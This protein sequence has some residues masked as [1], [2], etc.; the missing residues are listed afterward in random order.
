MN[1]RNLLTN[2]FHTISRESFPTW[3][4]HTPQRINSI[5]WNTIESHWYG[6]VEVRFCAA[7]TDPYHLTVT[8]ETIRLQWLKVSAISDLQTLHILSNTFTSTTH[9]IT[10]H[11]RI[12]GI[13]RLPCL[14][15]I[16]VIIALTHWP[17][18][19]RNQTRIRSQGVWHKHLHWTDVM[20]VS[21]Y[22]DNK[23]RLFDSLV[24]GNN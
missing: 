20:F 14:W 12:P 10:Q 15:F 6:N 16:W 24:G 9:H 18:A 11:I 3:S 4:P 21:R 5:K 22:I 1:P 13:A 7:L 8:F 17:C 2:L 19:K 23:W